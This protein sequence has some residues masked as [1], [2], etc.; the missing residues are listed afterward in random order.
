MYV[1]AYFHIKP[2]HVCLP[3]K[4]LLHG[5]AKVPRCVI[6]SEAVLV[7]GSVTSHTEF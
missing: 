3:L 1:S 6:G 5:S 4:E 7:S 2:G